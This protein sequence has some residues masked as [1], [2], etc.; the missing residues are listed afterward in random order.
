V[1]HVRQH[2]AS[3]VALVAALVCETFALRAGT[4]GLVG[5]AA[6]AVLCLAGLVLAFDLE[7]AGRITAYASAFTLTWN[8]WFLGPVRPGDLLVLIALMCFVVAAPNRPFPHLPIWVKSLGL[9]IIVVAMVA[10]VFPQSPGYFA[11]RIVL[12]GNGQPTVSTKG[13]ITSANLGVAFKFLVAVLAIPLA[14]AMAATKDRR[15]PKRL[16][17]AFTVGAAVSGLVALSGMVGFGLPAHLLGVPSGGGRQI[18]LSNQPNYLAAGEVLAA[19]LAMWLML[20]P[21]KRDRLVGAASL[22]AC[23]GGVYASGSRGGSGSIVIAVVLGIAI[24]PRARRFAPPAVLAGLIAAGGIF[25]F[26]PALGMHILRATRIIGGSSTSGSNEARSIVAHQGI[27]DFLHAPIAGVGLQV[28][29]EASMVYLQELAAGGL[30]LFVGMSAYM[31]GA[32]WVGLRLSRYSHLGPALATSVLAALVLNVFEADLTDRFY[33][34]PV[35]ILVALLE[36]RRQDRAGSVSQEP[37]L[38]TQPPH[39]LVSTR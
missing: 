29:W 6:I 24:L 4:L 35:A 33:Y 21:R 1:K 8:G 9:A 39:E 23:I 19:P 2:L 32:T 36:V 10:I 30:I 20:E 18:G 15:A 11:S 7:R 13:T 5:L 22:L 3:G 26:L 28:S 16:A 37:D 38:A 17:V 31:L 34:V 12:D 25:A 14:Y 27:V